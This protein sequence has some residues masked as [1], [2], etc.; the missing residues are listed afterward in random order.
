MSRRDLVVGGVLL[1]V[2]STPLSGRAQAAPQVGDI[3]PDL[4]LPDQ[5][6]ADT[7]LS[8]LWSEGPLVL[9][10]Y[11]KDFTPTCTAQALEFRDAGPQLAGLGLRV[12]GI[13][14]DTVG[15][16]RRF[17]ETYHLDFPVLSDVHARAAEAYGVRESDQG[18]AVAR[19][20]TL[21]IDRGGEILWVW[22]PVDPRGHAARVVS[23]A[24]HLQ[25]GEVAR[26]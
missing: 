1:C 8:A 25:L 10:F 7:T 20:C 13:S 4:T 23:Q 6:G 26:E 16:H 14:I 24:E 2:L 22:D 18:F 21:L 3:A 12:V 19:R 5:F 11:P 17:A 15:S 9:Y